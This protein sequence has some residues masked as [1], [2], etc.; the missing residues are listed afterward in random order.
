MLLSESYLAH[1]VGEF[2][3]TRHSGGIMAEWTCPDLKPRNRRGKKVK[4][5]RPR[6]MDYALFGVNTAYPLTAIEAKWVTKSSPLARKRF[7]DDVLRLEGVRNGN[8]P[9]HRFFL[10]AGLEEYVQA[11]IDDVYNS[12]SGSRENFISQF[13]P[14]ESEKNIEVERCNVGFRKYFKNY[15][16]NYRIDLP[17][18]YKAKLVFDSRFQGEPKDPTIEELKADGGYSKNVRVL[19][20]RIKSVSKRSTFVPTEDVW[21]DIE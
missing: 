4:R 18:T 17:R 6:Q 2:L 19:V 15:Y 11:F 21:A 14:V 12:G 3:R 10:M 5:G 9:M 8:G 1:P 20:W 7:V 16:A 13:L